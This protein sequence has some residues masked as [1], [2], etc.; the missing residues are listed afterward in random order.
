MIELLQRKYVIT[1]KENIFILL[2]ILFLILMP[3]DNFIKF[4]NKFI[5]FYKE[6]NSF[7]VILKM[8]LSDIRPLAL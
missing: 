7:S 3:L 4:T 6:Q 8:Q 1:Q 2:Y 5:K